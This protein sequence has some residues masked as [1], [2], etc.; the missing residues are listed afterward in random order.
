MDAYGNARW[1]RRV[2][3]EARKALIGFQN[4]L[5]ALVEFEGEDLHSYLAEQLTVVNNVMFTEGEANEAFT[6]GYAE[7][8]RIQGKIEVP[9][10]CGTI[11][12]SLHEAA[13]WG[14]FDMSVSLGELARS[15][16]PDDFFETDDE[17]TQWRLALGK[18][19]SAFREEWKG[20]AEDLEL[21]EWYARLKM[22]MVQAIPLAEKILPRPAKEQ[23]EAE[24]DSS[25]YDAMEVSLTRRFRPPLCT[26]CGDVRMR[27]TTS[28]PKGSRLRHLKCPKCE[29]TAKVSRVPRRP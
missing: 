4:V 28:G 17:P 24:S 7:L 6:A 18:H 1:L 26:A 14:V 21:S 2:S 13:T 25:A 10:F 19:Y 16:P 27:V 29:A 5:S 8:C 12:S 22:E 15:D 20:A 11:G 3:H 9:N 23:D